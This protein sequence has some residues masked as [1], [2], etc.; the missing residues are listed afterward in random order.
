M[1]LLVTVVLALFSVGLFAQESRE[2]ATM[3]ELQHQLQ[4]DPDM[5]ARMEAIERHT[6]HF[7]QN[8]NPNTG[9]MVITIPVVF[10]IVH[11]GDAYGTN[12]NIADEYVLAQLEQLNQDFALTNA[13]ASSIPQI[14]QPVAANTEI[15]FC[16]AQRKPDGTATN[17]I[18]RVNGGQASWST[19]QINSTLKPSTIWN[20][21]HYLNIWSVVFS[22]SGLL[23]YAQFPGGAANT[24]GIVVRFSTVGSLALPN[25]AGG[26][27]ARGRTATHEVGHWLNLRH[28]WGDATCGSDLVADTPTHNTSNSGCPTYPHLSTCT[29]TPIEMTM[30]YMDYT[31]DVCMYMFTAGQ[32]ARMQAVMASGGARV[33]LL[34]SQGCVPP[35][36]ESCGTPGGLSATRVSAGSAILNWNAVS[37]ATSYNVRWRAVGAATWNT[38]ISASLS[39]SISGLSASTTYEFQVQA[40]CGSATGAFSA[41][42][43]FTT[44]AQQ[45]CG[46]PGG[47][48]AFNITSSSATL[49]W[50][51]VSGAT[52]YNVRWRAVGATTWLT[53]AAMSSFVSISG[54]TQG[55]TY[56]FQVQAICGSVSG[57]FSGSANFTTTTQ[58]PGDCST[59]PVGLSVSNITANSATLSWTAVSAALSYNVRYRIVGSAIWTTVNVNSNT[60]NAIGLASGSAYEFQVQSLCAR[61]QSGFS[62]SSTFTTL[63][64]GGGCGTPGGL[65]A[66]NVTTTTATLNWVAVGGATSYNVRWR[67][68]GAATWN[69]ASTAGLSQAVAGLTAATNYE[70]QVQAV[71][72]SATGSFSAS[73][74]FT[75]AAE[76][77]CGTPTDLN[78]SGITTTTAT[79]NWAAVGGATSYNVRWR[80]VGAATWNTVSTA[81]LSQAVA[82]LT[83]ATNYEFQVQAVCGSTTGSFSASSNFTTLSEPQ[84]CSDNFEPNDAPSPS[85]PATALNVELQAQIAT[86]ADNDYFRFANDINSRNIRIDLT[87]LP[88]N[89]NLELYLD[90]VLVGSSQQGGTSPEVIIYNRAPV[91]SAFYARVYGVGGAFSSNCYTLQINTS[92]SNFRTDGTG[93]IIEG[94]TPAEAQVNFQLFPNP[95]NTT[96]NVDVA[97]A[98]E[99]KVQ[100]AILDVT[101]KVVFTQLYNL[102]E[103]QRRA[104]VDVSA[105]P[106][107]VYM[108]QVKDGHSTGMQKLSI[109]R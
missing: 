21:N 25:P 67:A 104:A 85:L 41:S 30:N 76:P 91:S 45:S 34:A 38:A 44:G 90:G 7:E 4:H 63:S 108:V 1:R 27:F 55:T 49:A 83:A 61:D 92:A 47:L 10:H 51:G 40:V 84:V 52:S 19:T 58:A 23:G 66:T 57:V 6:Q 11:N 20:R 8:Y 24:D 97:L 32:K 53:T 72:G 14:F 48:T 89:Y 107:G 69:T 54:L 68:V 28:I 64:S 22:S 43:N 73:S 59:P 5:A 82:G 99:S 79:L 102:D 26:T 13:D 42:S 65:S 86:S 96:L 17:G 106:A 15:Q 93:V 12:E 103:A 46:I 74:N 88:A 101:G 56:E 18:N 81:G 71:C 105:L 75:T 29:G 95:A 31:N 98:R 35:V 70:F 2:C 36:T 16:L 37:G 3:E 9:R 39:Q 80:A 50:N 109:V 78:V 100:V 77:S 87:N 60:Y 62:G 94:E 33:S